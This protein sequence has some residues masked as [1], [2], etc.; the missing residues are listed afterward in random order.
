MFTKGMKKGTIRFALKSE[1]ARDAKIAGSFS[2]WQPIPM[3]KQ[4]NGTFAVTVEAQPGLHEYKFILDGQWVA[5]PD[6]QNRSPNQYGS[7]NSIADVR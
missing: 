6:N 3:S 7:V 5:D 1:T 4:K 2:N